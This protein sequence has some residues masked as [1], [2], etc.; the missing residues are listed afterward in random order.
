MKRFT[1]D[2]ETTDGTIHNGVRIFAAD[3]LKAVK[4]ARTNS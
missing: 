2:L 4:I 3:R 1:F